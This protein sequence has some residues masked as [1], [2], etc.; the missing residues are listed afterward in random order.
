M[1]NTI[2]GF[3]SIFLMVSGGQSAFGQMAGAPA[4][5][6]IQVKEQFE[7]LLRR[8]RDFASDSSDPYELLR[9][10]PA[11]KDIVSLGLACLPYLLSAIGDERGACKY[12][13]TLVA[14]EILKCP[15]QPGIWSGRA[16]NKK[17]DSKLRNGYPEAE[18]EFPAL[19]KEW[20]ELK[21]ETDSME[22][23]H[24]VT[25]SDPEYKLLRTHRELT[26]LGEVYVKI[27]NLGIFVLPLLMQEIKRGKYDFLPI[28]QHLTDGAVPPANCDWPGRAAEACLKWWGKH[29]AEWTVD[30]S[31][32]PSERGSPDDQED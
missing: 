19:R 26:H 21:Q 25:E 23:W 4:E 15:P 30:V 27:Q 9:Q 18:E 1:R 28:V 20:F 6:M 32:L 3:I 29:S 12:E 24:D 13:L 8:A 31:Q 22:L 16:L 14:C 10:N 5:G 11:F 2:A 7:E 17:L